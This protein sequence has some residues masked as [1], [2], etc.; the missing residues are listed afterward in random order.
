VAT[1][2][3]GAW[4]VSAVPDTGRRR[5]YGDYIS[6]AET[7]PAVPDEAWQPFRERYRAFFPVADHWLDGRRCWL[8]QGHA[9]TILVDAGQGP[10]AGRLIGSLA[11][12][13]IQ[14]DDIDLVFLTH[15]DLDHTGWALTE[16]G[17]PRFPR[18]RYAV[19]RAE[20]D[21]AATPAARMRYERWGAYLDERVLPL[22]RLDILDLVA[23]GDEVATG[24][25]V[26]AAPGHTPGHC[27]L[28]VTDGDAKLLLA[29]DAFHHPAQIT[30]HGWTSIYDDDAAGASATRRRLTSMAAREGL[31][32]SATHF[33]GPA[34]G[35]VVVEGGKTYWKPT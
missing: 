8:L 10:A 17:V 19:A 24:V 2:A 33:P 3:V 15:L 7:F 27:A 30:E 14:P 13:G 11:A 20:W 35:R 28:L 16:H 21:H 31:L 34:F 26:L 29:A 1:A 12:L 4:T 32:V 25:S 5:D 9:T 18:A 6:L 23:G 22:A